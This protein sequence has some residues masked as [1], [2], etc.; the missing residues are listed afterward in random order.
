MPLAND[1]PAGQQ[2]RTSRRSFGEI[3]REAENVDGARLPPREPGYEFT[4]GRN[5]DTP[6][7]PY[8]SGA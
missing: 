2:V 1:V 3:V 8:E 7:N 4:N 6:K 5:F